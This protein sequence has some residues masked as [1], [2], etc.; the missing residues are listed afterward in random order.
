VKETIKLAVAVL[1]L[2]LA[3]AELIRL[4]LTLLG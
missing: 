3:F 1:Q 4:I 2:L